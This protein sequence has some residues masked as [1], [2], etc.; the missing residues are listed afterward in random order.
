MWRKK[1]VSQG[2]SKSG[3]I[4]EERCTSGTLKNAYMDP[5]KDGKQQTS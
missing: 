1:G 2:E 5:C 3:K 4:P